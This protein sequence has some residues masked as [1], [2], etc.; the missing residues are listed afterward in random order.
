MCGLSLGKRIC[1]W[2]GPINEG[3]YV[4]GVC[5]STFTM[6][7]KEPV[8]SS[9]PTTVTGTTRDQPGTIVTMEAE[10]ICFSTPSPRVEGPFLSVKETSHTR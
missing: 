7:A 4:H 10:P 1:M 2:F 9:E 6:I 5:R 8:I 3:T